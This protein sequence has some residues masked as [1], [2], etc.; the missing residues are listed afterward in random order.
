M[1]SKKEILRN[2][3]ERIQKGLSGEEDKSFISCY[4][5]AIG[6]DFDYHTLLFTMKDLYLAGT[7]TTS[8]T[9]QWMM[10]FLANH[11]YVQIRC[12]KEIDSVVSRSQPPSLDD[13]VSLPYVEATI[14]ELMRIRTLVPL[15]CLTLPWPRRRLEIS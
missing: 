2:V 9:L 13:K 7:E 6:T 5:E 11:P 15:G 10:I 14:L 1:T 3:K 12:Q 4:A 8:T